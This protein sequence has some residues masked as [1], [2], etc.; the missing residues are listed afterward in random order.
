MVNI[1][2]N[3]FHPNELFKPLH[4]P[5]NNPDAS[6]QVSSYPKVE[7]EK[8]F[9]LSP[10]GIIFMDMNGVVKAANPAAYKVGGYYE[11][12]FIGKHFSEIVTVSESDIAKSGKLLEMIK[13]DG[14]IKP[15]EWS[16]KRK[17][18][19]IG[20][21][22]VY[23][24]LLKE[25]RKPLGILV[26]KKD[27]TDRKH[28]ERLMQEGEAKYRDLYEKAPN[29]YFSVGVEGL[30]HK[31]NM[32]A[33][34]MLGYEEEELIGKPVLDLYANI[35][36]GKE[37]ASK[38]FE[39]FVA[40]EDTIDQELQMQKRDGTPIWISLTVNIIRGNNGQV[41]ESRSM[42][43]DITER[44]QAEEKLKESEDKFRSL[45]ERSPNMIFINKQGRIVYTNEKCEEATG[46]TR[47]EFYAPDFDFFNLIAPE[48]IELVKTN[49]N[50]HIQG[51]DVA[52]YEYSL[53]SKDGK[54][55]EA[56]ITTALIN[57]EGES[58]ILGAIT[59]ITERKRAEE[60]LKENEEKF[61]LLTENSVMGTFIIQDSKMV[62]VNP[63]FAMVFG[64]RPEEIINT[65][66]P[67]KF[68]HPD[69]KDYMMQR[70]ADRYT[71]KVTDRD[72]SFKG[73]KN[74]GSIIF[75]EA[76]A[77]LIEYRGKP[78]VMGTFIDI[79]ER[80]QAEDALKEAEITYR[81]LLDNT[82]DLIQ[83]VKPDGHFR[84]VNNAWRKTLGYSDEEL[85]NLTIFDII[86][87]DNLQ[88]CQ[89][90]FQKLMSGERVAR[91]ELA[92]ISKSGRVI[93]VEGNV[94]VKLTDGDPVYT[95]GIFRDITK[96]KYL[97]EHVHRLS[98]AISM[99][100][101]YIVI[102]DF[103]A[104]IIDINEKVLEMYGANSKDELQGKHFL[105]LIDPA[106]RGVVNDDVAEIME[107]G[108]LECREYTMI[109][110]QGKKCP[111]QVSTS[112][113]KDADGKPMGMV[114]VGRELIKSNS[115]GAEDKSTLE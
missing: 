64:Y 30:I 94:N 42:V 28:S 57:Y 111:V 1:L 66:D 49:Y 110:K 58:A 77:V 89:M 27:I 104:K 112:L 53:V 101:D 2:K 99:S 21:T 35:P 17:D 67:S 92:F 86:H 12:D 90:V 115:I 82:N 85:S 70:L 5:K 15:F 44:K 19:T 75:V 10:E 69:D 107:I 31:C 46:Y 29:A 50:K 100:P 73:V 109:S 83:S 105:E 9:E 65:M 55:I 97:E 6:K 33:A 45:A 79:T 41:L 23:A 74:D 61:R 78:A 98:N 80:K 26:I 3:R 54:R 71:G 60:A 51:E 62:Y 68:I 14:T 20:Y 24:S 108:Q 32:H 113:V 96:S 93:L 95:R 34:E 59:D 4:K 39:R 18:G 37:K 91:V 48:S 52:P 63:S 7:Y 76:T 38:V 103:D 40:G 25:N 87:P 88:H 81:D 102:T 56:I 43:V 106:E 11:K 72:I 84:Y 8:L 13:K 114:R 16:Y 22:E 36:Q 47:E